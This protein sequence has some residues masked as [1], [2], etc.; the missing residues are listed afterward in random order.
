MKVRGCHPRGKGNAPSAPVTQPKV[1][2]EGAYLLSP[3]LE[4][5]VLAICWSKT[6]EGHGQ[7]N[8]A[9]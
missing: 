1:V 9:I 8:P 3:T 6:V 5:P 4:S 2:R 7:W